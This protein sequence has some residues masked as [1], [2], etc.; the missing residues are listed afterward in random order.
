[1]SRI[2]KCLNIT[3]KCIQAVCTNDVLSSTEHGICH[4]VCWGVHTN[5]YSMKHCNDEAKHNRL[6]DVELFLIYLFVTVC[7]DPKQYYCSPEWV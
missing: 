1:M 4:A 5:V 6:H 7:M 2:M 3:L